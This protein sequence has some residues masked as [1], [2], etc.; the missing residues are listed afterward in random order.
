MSTKEERSL[1]KEE[2]SRRLCRWIAKGFTDVE[3]CYK[4]K[5]SNQEYIK[6]RA[7]NQQL[8]EDYQQ[9]LEEQ[10]QWYEKHLRKRAVKG[11][12]EVTKDAKGNVKKSVHKWDTDALLK[13]LAARNPKYRT[14]VKASDVT[15]NF[16]FAGT[17]EA[18]RQRL[19]RLKK[20][21]E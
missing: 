18:A 7:E 10:V 17:L 3:A 6:M 13:L 5:I 20:V 1:V 4:A 8:Q 15:V 2:L 11:Y 21:E 16:D 9:A 12:T 19:K 14:A